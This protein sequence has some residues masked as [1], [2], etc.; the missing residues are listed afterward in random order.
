M[1][2]DLDEHVPKA[3]LFQVDHDTRVE[4]ALVETDQPVHVGCHERQVVDVVEQLHLHL[5]RVAELCRICADFG[6]FR[7]T[8]RSSHYGGRRRR[9]VKSRGGMQG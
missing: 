7:I 8:E 3:F 6:E 1:R 5:L 4:D 2:A 9:R